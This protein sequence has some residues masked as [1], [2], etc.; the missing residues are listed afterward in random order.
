MKHG[1]EGRPERRNPMRKVSEIKDKNVWACVM[2][3]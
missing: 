1:H 2:H 3:R